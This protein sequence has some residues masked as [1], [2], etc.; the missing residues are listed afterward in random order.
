M[1]DARENRALKLMS[2]LPL[3]ESMQPI[4]PGLTY[5]LS[6]TLNLRDALAEMI[7]QGVDEVAVENTAKAPVGSISMERLLQLGKRS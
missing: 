4:K 6:E 3:K 1:F 7:W 5:G 2:L